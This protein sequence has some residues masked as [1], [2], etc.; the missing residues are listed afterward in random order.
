MPASMAQNQQR[1]LTHLICSTNPHLE[2]TLGLSMEG[3][4]ICESGQ[5]DVG[6]PVLVHPVIPVLPTHKIVLNDNSS[7]EC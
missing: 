5:Q 7:D 2:E 6:G 4:T 1:Q 3:T